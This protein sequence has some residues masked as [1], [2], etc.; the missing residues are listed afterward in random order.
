MNHDRGGDSDAGKEAG[1]DCDDCEHSEKTS[2]GTLY[3]PER[4]FQ[5]NIRFSVRSLFI[6]H[7]A[8]LVRRV[9]DTCA[10]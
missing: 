1:S 4:H 7:R 2:E 10:R 3:L 6:L 5:K 9:Y 8:I